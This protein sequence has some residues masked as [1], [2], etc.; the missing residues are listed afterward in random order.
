MG[1]INFGFFKEIFYPHKNLLSDDSLLDP[2]N[3]LG[4]AMGDPTEQISEPE[5]DLEPEAEQKLKLE[6][7]IPSGTKVE[8]LNL[9]NHLLFVG[10]VRVISNDRLRIRTESPGDKLPRILYGTK[11]KVRGFQK[12][13]Q[14]F[15]LFGIVTQ[16]TSEFWHVEKLEY[17]QNQESRNFFRQSIE[18]EGEILT[19]TGGLDSPHIPCKILDVSAGG[20]RILTKEVYQEGGR[21]V[22][23]IGFL[24]EEE[25]FIF[26]CQIQ[27]VTEREHNWWE[28][29]CQF[30]SLPEKEQERIL[31]V[32]FALQRQV[33][34]H[35]REVLQ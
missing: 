7:E 8:V 19:G 25:P 34:Q 30:L 20:V 33:L 1:I 31:R 21:F 14:T 28:Y 4:D 2:E 18:L 6:P 27:R 10:R 23:R 16:N 15:A 13:S 32:V 35:Q 24:P 11:V 29:G 12:N 3:M 17:L 5:T 22:L 26:T 9:E